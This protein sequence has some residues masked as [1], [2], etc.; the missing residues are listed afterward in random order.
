MK[1]TLFLSLFI[2]AFSITHTSSQTFSYIERPM[3]FQGVQNIGSKAAT[4][5]IGILHCSAIWVKYRVEH[6]EIFG[7]VFRGPIP[8]NT[9]VHSVNIEKGQGANCIGKSNSNELVGAYHELEVPYG[10]CGVSWNQDN[11]RFTYSAAVLMRLRVY[12]A[13]SIFHEYRLRQPFTCIGDSTYNADFN[14]EYLAQTEDLP[15]DWEGFSVDIKSG[16][17]SEVLPS[18]GEFDL[19]TQV[20]TLTIGLHDNMTDIYRLFVDECWG[21]FHEDR[22]MAPR[23]VFVKSQGCFDQGLVEKISDDPYTIRFAAIGYDDD[24]DVEE[25][26][27]IHCNIN[28]CRKAGSDEKCTKDCSKTRHRM[29]LTN[30][31]GKSTIPLPYSKYIRTNGYQIMRSA[32]VQPRASIKKNGE[33]VI[34]HH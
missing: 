23:L 29:I 1:S 34:A 9:V 18:F 12:R 28:T 32:T 14:L 11:N 7:V 19:P 3:M 30:R 10:G 31:T 5:A 22:N 2:F 27:H 16:I 4:S 15:A 24:N 33:V 6:K 25:K 26:M 13:P 20:I 8:D 17:L 21:N